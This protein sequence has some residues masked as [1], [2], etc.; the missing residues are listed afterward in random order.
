[1]DE[2]PHAPI[3][4][5]LYNPETDEVIRECSRSF[6]PSKFLKRALRI[7]K[8]LNAAKARGEELDE[9]LVDELYGLVSDFFAITVDE[10]ENGTDVEELI[11]VIVAIQARAANLMP[12][13]FPSPR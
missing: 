6:I 12:P 11:A 10:V 3:R 5:T 8:M 13:N 4:L 7:L 2:K 9:E 1:M